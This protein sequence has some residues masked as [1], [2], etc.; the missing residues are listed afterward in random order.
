ME[1]GHDEETD[2]AGNKTEELNAIVRGDAMSD[3]FGNP[4]VFED[5]GAAGGKDNKAKEER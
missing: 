5:D 2:S 4:L 1:T 3:I